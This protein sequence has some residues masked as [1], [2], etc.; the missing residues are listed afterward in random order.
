MN[1]LGDISEAGEFLDD[2]FD[3]AEVLEFW[4]TSELMSL[5]SLPRN[6]VIS[7]P[8]FKIRQQLYQLDHPKLRSNEIRRAE[9]MSLSLSLRDY[10]LLELVL[11]LSHHRR[12]PP[13][14]N[15]ANSQYGL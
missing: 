10:L 13:D 11:R 8:A 1:E 5:S 12:L 15:T 14:P 9:G 6:K 3:D 7:C 2:Q 4:S